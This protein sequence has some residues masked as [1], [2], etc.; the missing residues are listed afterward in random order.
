MTSSHV[1]SLPIGHV[2]EGYCVQRVLGAGGFGITYL[3]EEVTIGRK[4]AIKE[5]LPAGFAARGR[6]SYSVQPLS[7][8]TREQYKWGLDRFR[9]EAAT[10]VNFEHPNIVTVY[11]YFE[12]NGTAYLVMQYVEGHALDALLGK[13]GTLS[14]NE[15]EEVLLPI[16]DGLEQVHKTGFLHRDIKPANIY[17]RKDGRPVLLDFGA[18]RLAIGQESRSLTAIV[19]EGYAPFEQYEARGD[20]GPWSDVYALGAVL[21][22]CTTGNKPPPAPERISARISG[23]PDPLEPASVVARGRYG[24][25]LLVAT[26]RALGLTRDE[27]P[28]NVGELRRLLRGDDLDSA[29]QSTPVSALASAMARPASET[30]LLSPSGESGRRSGGVRGEGEPKRKPRWLIPAGAVGA[31]ALAAVGYFVLAPKSADNRTQPAASSENADALAQNAAVEATRLVDEANGAI[32]RGDFAA[33]RT[34][35][36]DAKRRVEEGLQRR[37]D[38]PRLRQA[39][40]DIA[41]AERGLAT[42]AA[43]RLKELVD[44]AEREMQRGDHDAAQRQLDEAAR[45][46]AAAAE[47][48]AARRRLNEARNRAE[49]ERKRRLEEEQKRQ[50]DTDTQRRAEAERQRQAEA[51]QRDRATRADTFSSLARDRLGAARTAL[52][53]A[54]FAEARRL[55]EE[56]RGFLR[57]ALDLVPQSASAAAVQRDLDLLQGELRQRIADRVAALV[58]DAKAAIGRGQLDEAERLLADVADLD[59]TAPSLVSARRELAAAR[60]RADEERRRGSADQRERETRADTFAG[61]ARER[62]TEARAALQQSRYAEARRLARESQG[63]VRSAVGIYPSSASAAAVQRDLDQFQG[64]L[65]QRIDNR[66]AALVTE[67]RAFMARGQFDDADRRLTDAAAL[68]PTSAAV[69]SVRRELAAARQ[70]ADDERRKKEAEERAKAEDERRR[71]DDARKKAEEA[72]KAETERREKETRA[73][74]YASLARQRLDAGNAAL[75]QSR[76]VEARRLAEECAGFIR[77]GELIYASAANLVAVKRDLAEFQRMLAQRVAAR[78]ADLVRSAR[79]HIKEK[80]LAEAQR[81]LDEAATLD[82]AAVVEARRE[83]DAARKQAEDDARKKSEDERKQREEEAAKRELDERKKREEEA[84]KSGADADAEQRAKTRD[85]VRDSAFDARTRRGTAYFVFEKSDI[86]AAVAAMIGR[87]ADAA[88]AEKDGYLSLICGHDQLEVADAAAGRRLALLR[89]A[90]VQT[91]A[92]GRG[93]APRQV[94]AALATAGKGPDFRRVAFAVQVEKPEA[95]KPEAGKPD[96]SK[97]DDKAPAGAIRLAGR[98][99]SFSRLSREKRATLR[100][101]LVFGA[102]GA[103]TATCSAEAPDGAQSACFGQQSG[104]GTWSLNGNTLCLTSAVLGLASQSCYQLSGEGNQLVAS[105]AGV[106]A[107]PMFLR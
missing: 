63:F 71:Q 31:L 67:A 37:P 86:S 11:R 17:I 59:A 85:I 33:G 72:V 51:E 79:E 8:A 106:V 24:M 76:H 3:A 88:K 94:R 100:V 6:D 4:V 90:A 92:A 22:R 39:Q 65:S 9:K 70:R 43:A 73:D 74:T 68:E 42:R 78:V 44:G 12:A 60:Q 99:A 55:V 97:P 5:Y 38:H 47:I 105:G 91:I 80:R 61:L 18:A 45:I 98:T 28:Q 62:L 89:C 16:L 46:D 35:L 41:A 48:E 103:L 14:A 10:L 30:I 26:D 27:R 107:G 50:A 104:P 93:L 1:N 66:V 57:N 53:Q 20:Q 2:F 101:T 77:D 23:R 102:G 69:A 95:G 54:R 64:E 36:A 83:L 81:E 34:R 87:A 84:R 75:R 19:S 32:A 25:A 82:R 58:N 49:G 21:Y 56:A 52:Q 7:E 15:I 13:G 29:I 40:Q 96:A